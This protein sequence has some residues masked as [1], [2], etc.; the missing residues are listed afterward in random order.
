MSR[1]W[2]KN[3]WNFI[4]QIYATIVIGENGAPALESDPKSVK[5]VLVPDGVT[6]KGY[7]YEYGDILIGDQLPYK[8]AQANDIICFSKAVS[9]SGKK[10][11][12]QI[13]VP[14]DGNF[15]SLIK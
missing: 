2:R 14:Q 9:I 5:I 11:A 3:S 7:H 13:T 10:F 15:L 8:K 4:E 12:G 6:V 1:V